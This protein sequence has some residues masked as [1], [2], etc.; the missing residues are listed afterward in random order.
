MYYG[1]KREAK[2]MIARELVKMGWKIY[3]WKNDESDAMIDYYSPA[4]WNG[5]AE[6]NGYVLCIDQ[7]NTRY[8]GFE[9]K[10]YIGG[11]SGYKTNTRIQKLL[12]MMN[13]PASTENEKASCAVLIE[14]EREKDASIQKWVVTETYPIFSF[15]NPRGT[16]WHIEKDGQIIA[17]GKG[18]FAVNEYDWENKEKTEFQQKAEKVQALIKRFEKVISETDAL[19]AEVIQVPVKVIKEV[20]KTVTNV[21]QNDINDGFTFIMKVGYT[22]GK[23]KGNKY[24]FT[25]K[26][27]DYITFAQLTKNNKPSTSIGK[28]WSLTI[29]RINDLLKKG[30]IAVIEFVEV[31]EYKE[32]TV[33]R[34][35][36]RK[37]TV[38]DVPAIETTEE[39]Q[40][41]VSDNTE[42]SEVTEPATTRQLWALHCATKLDTRGMKIS[43]TKAS[44]LITKSKVGHN[45]ILEVK[46]YMNT[47][48]AIASEKSNNDEAK[49]EKKDEERSQTKY[50]SKIDKQIE[51]IQNKLNSISGEYLTNTWKRQNEEESREEKREQ[52]RFDIAMLQL[53]REKAATNELT[54]LEIALLNN[55][56]REDIRCKYNSKTRHNF[57]IKYPE[58]DPKLDPDGMWNLEVPKRQKRY[59]KVNIYNTEQL[60]EAVNQ[61]GELVKV[62]ETPSNPIEQQIKKLENE[63]KLRKITGYF[64]T[65]KTIV[66]RMIE[67]ADI[68]D[69]ETILEPSAG[70]GN[71]LDGI[72][73]YID[74]NGLQA[75]LHGIECNYSLR[76]I[77]ELKQYKV[78]GDD[79]TEFIPFA[80][81]D[82]VIMNPPFEKNQDTD[83]VLKAYECLNDGGKL[84]AIMSLHWTFANDSKSVHFRNWLN[85][86][87]YYEKLPDGSFKESGTGVS[88]VI[89]V[90]DKLEE[91]KE[92]IK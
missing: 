79:F 90:I 14:K 78:V 6:K 44:E 25:N 58:I 47:N 33:Y 85:G 55:A 27:G 83:H 15:T 77:L 54:Q 65:P 26:R 91:M 32:K 66:Q 28:S 4:D 17:K 18:V 74:D 76:H 8:S 39:V 43:K 9:Q 21:T 67:F 69:G 11:N 57:V 53:F 12:A 31:T 84:V 1:D 38:S 20:E 35:T 71:I 16:S 68:K 52:Y 51:S 64:P 5:I 50:I 41:T 75:E 56:F 36:V 30:H 22:H 82:R 13:D 89:V 2:V 59:N 62:I 10:Q 60:K 45:I 63:V 61:Y 40:A 86:K 48:A 37:Q 34:K 29:D 42:E 81:Y 49:T 87:G 72:K 3:G 70:N 7:N 73:Q 24:T 46:A 23:N 80:K 88:T 92:G 19:K